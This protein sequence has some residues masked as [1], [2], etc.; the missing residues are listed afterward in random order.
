MVAPS[1][2]R[3]IRTELSARGLPTSHSAQT[4]PMSPR[5]PTQGNLARGTDVAAASLSPAAMPARRRKKT[6]LADFIA[7]QEAEDR[8]AMFQPMRQLQRVLAVETVQPIVDLAYSKYPEVQRDAAAALN[9]LSLSSDNKNA[10]V[11]AGCLRP[12]LLLATSGDRAVRRDA[13]GA[14]ANLS[15]EEEIRTKIVDKGG[16]PALIGAASSSRDIGATRSAAEALVNFASSVVGRGVLVR[17]GGLRCIIGLLRPRDRQAQKLGLIAMQK[18]AA[19]G[20]RTRDDPEGDGYAELLLEEH[21]LQPL[22]E[23]MARPDDEVRQ[24]AV[25]VLLNIAEPSEPNKARLARSD[26]LSSLVALAGCSHTPTQRDAASCLELLSSLAPNRPKVLEAG[27][28]PVL[29][30]LARSYDLP[31]KLHAATTLM[32]LASGALPAKLQLIDE[33]VPKVLVVLAQI[34]H[35]RIARAAT[36]ALEELSEAAAQSLRG[37][38]AVAAALLKQGVLPP[39]LSLCAARDEAVQR[40]ALATLCNLFTPETTKQLLSQGSSRGGDGAQGVLGTIATAA[41]MPDRA[42]Q[43]DCAK[44]LV[45]LASLSTSHALLL[46]ARGVCGALNAL[47][48]STNL[49]TLHAT[50]TTLAALAVALRDEEEAQ[51]AAKEEGGAAEPRAKAKAAPTA[52]GDEGGEKGQAEDGGGEEGGEAA[53]AEPDLRAPLHAR[54]AAAKGALGDVS[55]LLLE[56]RRN[57]SKEARRGSVARGAPLL[58]AKAT[59][60]ELA[61]ASSTKELWTR[62]QGNFGKPAARVI[63]LA[64]SLQNDDL[65]TVADE[66]LCVL[67]PDYSASGKMGGVRRS[68]GG[69]S[70]LKPHQMTGDD[71]ALHHGALRIQASFRGRQGRAKVVEHKKQQQQ[72]EREKAVARDRRGSRGGAAPRRPLS[73]PGPSSGRLKLGAAKLV[74]LVKVGVRPDS[75]RETAATGG[76]S[77][78]PAGAAERRGSTA[79]P[80]G[81]TPRKITFSEPPS[82]Q[83]PASALPSP[84]AVQYDKMQ[85]GLLGGTPVGMTP[86]APT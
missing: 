37:G 29:L 43:S 47:L 14:L 49:T 51:Q 19:A 31:L 85:K 20:I 10:L 53:A 73:A 58:V 54:A 46:A 48:L 27:A 56:A 75:A 55:D 59:Q 16:L 62:L 67:L 84:R 15:T 28:L 33:G 76:A 61:A 86:A 13:L 63:Q 60:E 65:G 69:S 68:G 22:L 81:E 44:A 77:A 6:T 2:A 40:W 21:A 18:L 25:K 38:G 52:G 72:Q 30:A 17:G 82:T 8:S 1:S 35:R 79:A 64:T 23:L 34:A 71:A 3:F 57:V 36:H 4:Q 32:Y 5:R 26:V 42:I 24:Q 12:L 41:L 39:L 66:V 7:E 74:G 70:P 50:V 80:A 83:R 78:A 11:Q 45:E 9:T